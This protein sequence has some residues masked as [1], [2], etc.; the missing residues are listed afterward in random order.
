MDP[1]PALPAAPPA[2]RRY[3]YDWLRVIGVGL[4]FL[5]HCASAFVPWAPQIGGLDKSKWFGEL[6]W[7]GGAWLMPLSMLLAGS[8]TWYALRRRT[9]AQYLRERTARIFLPLLVCMALLVVPTTCTC[10]SWRICM[11][12]RFSACHSSC[13]CG[14]R[15]GRR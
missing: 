9:A 10:G 4:V 2:A 1:N 11:S 7:I 6:I 14:G 8:S 5:A 12:M 15:P 13:G 3:D